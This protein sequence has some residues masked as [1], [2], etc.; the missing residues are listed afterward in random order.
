MWSATMRPRL[1]T[2][3]ARSGNFLKNLMRRIELP[4]EVNRSSVTSSSGSTGVNR[5]LAALRTHLRAEIG[6][7]ST[8]R[9]LE[10][11]FEFTNGT[12]L[13]D[14]RFVDDSSLAQIR[15]RRRTSDQGSAP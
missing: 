5:Q 7:D 3:L 4:G 9:P 6:A 10:K 12:K 11:M 14:P 15:I 1:Q 13:E 8:M 2:S